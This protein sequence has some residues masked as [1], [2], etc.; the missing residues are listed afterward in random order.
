M[1]CSLKPLWFVLIFLLLIAGAFWAVTFWRSRLVDTSDLENIHGI[2]F[3]TYANQAL[4]TEKLAHTN[5]YLR[6]SR[7]ARRLD[8][9]V[10][11]TPTAITSLSVGI[12]DNPFWLSYNKINL[13]CTAAELAN[14]AVLTKTVTI[15]VTDKIAD[16][17]GS[18]DLMF[19][20]T[21]PTSQAGE[22]AGVNDRTVWQLH[23]LSVR[24]EPALP[25]RSS[26][27]DFIK[28]FITRA[29]PL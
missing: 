6:H 8:L 13:C 25:D 28:S 10:S 12:R 14:P 3:P 27:R 26:L 15:P 16:R 22:D 2:P 17:D 9:T 4:I 23:D 19:F 7:L 24:D 21:N 11:F 20:A 18:L 29:K 5:L 1:A